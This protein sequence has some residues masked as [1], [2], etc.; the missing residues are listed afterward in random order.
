MD[1]QVYLFIHLLIVILVVSRSW[2]FEINLEHEQVFLWT[3]SYAF[4]SLGSIYPRNRR[5]VNIFRNCQTLTLLV[6]FY[7]PTAYQSLN[8]SLSS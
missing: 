7:I 2:L 1:M 6:P 4:I 3:Y 8:S 5:M